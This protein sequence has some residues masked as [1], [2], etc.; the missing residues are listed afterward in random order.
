MV[1]QLLERVVADNHA[2]LP[3]EGGESFAL[4]AGFACPVHPGKPT[5]PSAVADA[6]GSATL[7]IIWKP[8]GDRFGSQIVTP[9]GV[10]KLPLKSLG[11]MDY[12]PERARTASKHHVGGA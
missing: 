10:R 3:R 12:R 11:G 2:I 4:G 6:R 7:D 1:K 5:K 9:K 8:Y